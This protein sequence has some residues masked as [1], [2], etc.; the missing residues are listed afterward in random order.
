MQVPVVI[1]LEASAPG[2]GGFPIEVGY[3]HR[4]GD[5]WCSL[6]RP[7]PGWRDWDE[8]CFCRHLIARD[9][10]QI[11]GRTTPE[12]A[13][14]LNQRLQ[15]LTVYSEAE[16]GGYYRLHQLFS[17]AGAEPA[18]RLADLREIISAPQRQIWQ[19][20]RIQIEKELSLTRRRASNQAKIAQLTWLRTFDTVHAG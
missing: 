2:R 16:G 1:A 3:S 15:G 12:I 9:M 14:L 6:V 8:T 19:L 18:F 13:A 4:H 11:A 7:E 5:G 20:T 17:A 10:L